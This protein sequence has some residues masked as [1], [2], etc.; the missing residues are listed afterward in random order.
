MLTAYTRLLLL[1]W[2]TVSAWDI[3]TTSSLRRT[4]ETNLNNH[5]LETSWISLHGPHER[6][7]NY[8][9]DVYQLKR[10]MGYCYITLRR[11]SCYCVSQCGCCTRAY[12][13]VIRG[14][15]VAHT[16]YIQTW[17]Q[18]PHAKAKRMHSVRSWLMLHFQWRFDSILS[19]P[20][21]NM[22]APTRFYTLLLFRGARNTL[23]HCSPVCVRVSNC[24]PFQTARADRRACG[25]HISCNREHRRNVRMSI[26]TFVIIVVH[27]TQTFPYRTKNL[28]THICNTCLRSE[29]V[30]AY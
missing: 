3:Q 17:T 26:I 21:E 14:L 29:R 10:Y 2:K 7:L 9:F 6:W 11:V 5:I 27:C 22:H 12:F 24:T 19:V 1:M 13:R 4:E 15:R 16:Q 8:I 30:R 18:S 23:S 28:N 20:A 25:C